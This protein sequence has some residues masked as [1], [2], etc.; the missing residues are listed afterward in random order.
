VNGPA[1]AELPRPVVPPDVYDEEYYLKACAG[2]A[3][4][5]ASEGTEVASIYPGV[6][7]LAKLRPGE[8][9][10]DI[11]TG[12]GELLAVAVREG[13]RRAIGVEYASAAAALARRTLAAHGVADKAEVIE[14]D[15]RSIPVD[16]RT[17]DLVTMIDV[18]EHLAHDELS[19][20]LREALRILK[21]GGRIFVH[22]FPSRTLYN[23]TYR[24]QRLLVPG[25]RKRWPADP[26]INEYEHLMH[27]N[28]QTLRS[29]RRY[30]RD[31]GFAHARS[32]VGRWT[33][34]DFVPDERAKRLYRRL[35]AFPLTKRFG[36]ADLFAEGIRPP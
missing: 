16:D 33:Y 20:S 6:L 5:A 14:A 22:T 3:E 11:G 26:R 31:A 4:W 29:L 32:R 25:R 18:V 36:I 34:T 10:V 9:L 24:L 30:L 2:Y 21:P 27:V 1:D 19:H 15:A 17:A 35:T 7:H 12:R 28:E 8:T 13:A 23:V